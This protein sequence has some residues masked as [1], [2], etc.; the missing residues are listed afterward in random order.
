VVHRIQPFATEYFTPGGALP[1]SF[2]AGAARIAGDIATGVA[3]GP[4]PFFPAG[5]PAAPPVADA[6]RALTLAQLTAFWKD[7]IRAWLRAMQLDVAEDAA[8]DTAL[9][10]AP[11]NLDAL[12]AYS[13]RATALA[14]RLKTAGVDAGAASARLA[15][16]RALPPGALG[17][18][19]WEQRDREV[20]PLAR[21]LAPVLPGAGRRSIDLA[22]PA[23]VRLAGEVLLAGDVPAGQTVLVYRA[24]NYED[25]PRHQLEA[26][27]QTMALAVQAGG[28]AGGRVLGLDRPGPEPLPAIAPDEARRHLAALIEGYWQGQRRPL[29]FAPAASSV[30]AKALAAGKD[31]VEALEQARGEWN[32]E[33]YRDRPGGEGMAPEAQLAWRDA[34]PFAAP[35]D[36]EWIRWAR[37]VATPLNDWW[38]G[39]TGA[40]GA[41]P[42]PKKNSRRKT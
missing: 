15:A 41:E 11:L 37:E 6:T 23:G 34:D 30:L 17:R 19:A 35:H 36:Q 28:A 16:D 42:A 21:G 18:L 26:F 33:P 1:G 10:D 32:R 25:A 24:G 7:P 22:L 9:D 13:V 8:D 5:P 4:R 2:D 20:E 38:H 31:E 27:I 3:G 39:S 12:Q 14:V 29:C 40:A